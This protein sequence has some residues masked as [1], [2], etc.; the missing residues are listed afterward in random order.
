MSVA[1]KKS[2]CKLEHS[3]E[4]VT[5]V[6]R[7]QVLD[8]WTS[9][10]SISQHLDQNNLKLHA[11]AEKHRTELSSRKHT[12]NLQERASAE[13]DTHVNQKTTLNVER[14]CSPANC[15]TRHCMP[16]G[17]HNTGNKVLT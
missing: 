6:I 17:W 14:Q 5:R 7:I 8:V 16:R 4:L 1:C 15:M 3:A 11:S 9:I 10:E 13:V 2:G 12:Q